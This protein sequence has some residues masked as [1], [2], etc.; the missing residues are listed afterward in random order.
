M[1]DVSGT[2]TTRRSQTG[3]R[4]STDHSNSGFP[5]RTTNALALPEPRR[6]PLPPAGT[7]PTTVMLVSG[8]GRGAVAAGV[9][10]L[11]QL[12]EVRLGLVLLHLERVHQLGG[13][14]LLG[15]G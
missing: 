3:R 2:A 15:P 8:R 5:P 13:E 14:D 1:S 4:A 12:L 11:D 9:R 10:V 6:S 7:I